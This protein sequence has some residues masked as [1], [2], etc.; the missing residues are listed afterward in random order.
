M[1]VLLTS[2]WRLGR[3]FQRFGAQPRLAHARLK[4]LEAL[5]AEAARAQVDAVVCAGD[6]F[7][8]P[9][10]ARELRDAVFSLFASAKVK[11][12]VVPGDRDPL[13]AGS[14]WEE[15]LPASV[16]LVRD[17]AQVISLGKGA[18]V[19]SPTRAHVEATEAW[20]RL[21]SVSAGVKLGVAHVARREPAA[22]PSGFA[23]LLLGGRAEFG[24]GDT[25]KRLVF[26]GAHEPEDFERVGR[27]ALIN[28]N[29]S[30]QVVVE[31]RVTQHLTWQP[32]RVDSLAALQ[33]LQARPDL[34]QHVLR[35][36]V[37]GAWSLGDAVELE[38]ALERFAE[39]VDVVFE[40]ERAFQLE[41]DDLSLFEHAPATVQAAAR[42]L[43]ERAADDAERL[44]ALRALSLLAEE[45]ARTG[46]SLK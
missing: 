19:A 8:S 3:S 46:A 20:E 17:D 23:A 41:T 44:T 1:K 22:V 30:G 15:E 34:G 27:V 11:V 14:V 36:E 4:A 40:L 24:F 18:L 35:V 7:E 37:T 43:L 45:V 9:R 10:P 12:V 33:R 6:L 13:V 5:L 25:E 28:V 39:R 21:Q 31:P 16:T 42:A 29:A 38:R 26:S 32:V 2:D